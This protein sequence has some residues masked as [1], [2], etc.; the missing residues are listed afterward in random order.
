MTEALAPHQAEWLSLIA[1]QLRTARAQVQQPAPLNVLA[2]SSLHDAV[3]SL[4]SLCSEA[5]GANVKNRADFI[6]LFD[7]VEVR[8]AELP[9]ISGHRSA[10]NAL[11]QARVGFKHHGN[12]ADELTLKR[13]LAN[14]ENFLSDLAGA[15]F[16][17]RLDEVSLLLF[18]RNEKVRQ[19]VDNAGARWAAG[20]RHEAMQD[21]WLAFD[22]LVTDY[23]ARKSWH[24]GKT[25]FSTKPSFLPSVFDLKREGKVAEKAF[26][27]L[28]SLDSWV[29]I[30]AIGVD[31]RRYAYFDAHT[32][33]GMKVLSGDVRFHWRPDAELSDEVFLRCQA[34]V[35]DTALELGEDDFTFDAWA[36]R[37][38]AASEAAA[39]E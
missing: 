22:D 35:V 37:K 18:I 10:M 25:L 9:S 2:I 39:E 17:V 19:Y 12:R 21:L 20:E 36:A 16:S 14:G 29:R 6:Q 26:E 32:P 1:Y 27:W 4:L 15:V 5:L 24:P 13:H 8:L 31:T 3:E 7:A 38:A 28:E 33:T 23:Q 34:F 11:N 30:L